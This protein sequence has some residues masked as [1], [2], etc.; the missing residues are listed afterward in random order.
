MSRR[1]QRR[2][3]ASKSRSRGKISSGWIYRILTILVLAVILAGFGGYFWLKS[4]LNSDDFRVFLGE[5]V[6][7]AMGA[8]A[9]FEL[10]E[11][12]GMQAKTAGMSSENGKLIRS[13]NADGI[14]A[15]LNLSGVRRGVWEVSDLRVKQLDIL[16][17]T[18]NDDSRVVADDGND[19]SPQASAPS[20]DGGFLSGLLPKR[21]ELS[22]AEIEWL[23]LDLQT[24]GGSLKASN[25][26]TRIDAAR[27]NGAYDVNLADGLIET[28]WFGSPLDL[29]SAR[30]KYQDG[31]IFLT[32]LKAGVYER[33]VLTLSGEVD[34]GQF[35]SPRS[36][37]FSPGVF[38]RM[39]LQVT[40]WCVVLWSWNEGC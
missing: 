21:A 10:F 36:L 2:K 8:E 29:V 18:R 9:N 15:K 33:G 22:S 1:A 24:A 37:R 7:A 11:W 20:D 23:N 30:G 16:I 40:P 35:G 12:Q 25:V 6:G 28:T 14:Q 26:I 32:S 4:Y 38:L 34:G 3:P 31:R 13:M 17:D 39:G 19:D 27:A 5:K